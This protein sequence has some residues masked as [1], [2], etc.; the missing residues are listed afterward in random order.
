[1]RDGKKYYQDHKKEESERK[2]KYYR[3]NKEKVTK[4]IKRYQEEHKEEMK[5]YQKEWQQE[6]KERVNAKSKR[7]RQKMDPKLYYV[8]NK[9]K[10]KETARKCRYGLSP[11]NF[12]ILW[13]K[14]DGFCP[15]C[16]LPL[17]DKFSID[18]NHENSKIRGIIH[19]GCNLFIGLLEK[20]ISNLGNILKYLEED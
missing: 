13:E 10:F 16:Q 7:W 1:M 3:D 20:R 2:G 14:Q 12:K 15:I 5:K 11:E 9:E 18:H 19:Q 8:K 17:L 4:R 6:N